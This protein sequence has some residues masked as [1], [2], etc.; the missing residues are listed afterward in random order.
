VLRTIALAQQH[1]DPA[2]GS[3]RGL[4]SGF[5]GE[6][7]PPTWATGEAHPASE[8][9]RRARIDLIARDFEARCAAANRRRQR[10]REVIDAHVFDDIWHAALDR[11]REAAEASQAECMLV[12]LSSPLCSDSG[13]AIKTAEAD[14]PLTLRGGTA[15]IDVRCKRDLK[16]RGCS[17]SAQVL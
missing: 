11:T 1:A 14:W 8:Q 13:R 5:F 6:Y 15:E 10:T 3:H 9:T 4:L 17:S 12:R 7:H 2:A 16:P